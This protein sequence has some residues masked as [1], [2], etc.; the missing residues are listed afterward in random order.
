VLDARRHAR[1]DWTQVAQYRADRRL[2]DPIFWMSIAQGF[3]WCRTFRTAP[4][5]SASWNSS[6]SSA[7]GPPGRTAGFKALTT[8]HATPPEGA[9]AAW[10]FVTLVF[11]MMVGT[12][13][14]PHILML[15]HDA[16]GA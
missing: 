6:R 7:S 15:F 14:L 8:L 2:P 16:V 9:L 3:S 12:A 13:S 5:C 4:P 11:C 10:K 1:G